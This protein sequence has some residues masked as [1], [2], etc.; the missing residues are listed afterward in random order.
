MEIPKRCKS[1]Q[2]CKECNYKA[3]HLSWKE[4][5][6]LK[7]IE[8]GLSYDMKKAKWIAKYPFKTDPSV[9]SDNRSQAL[10]LMK[11]LEKRLIKTKML[12]DFNTQF[13]DA[14]DRGVFRELEDPSSYQGPVNYIS[15][16]DTYKSRDQVTTPI[17]L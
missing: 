3:L 12:D 4:N 11:G 2:C 10:S 17:H 5:E 1:C 9:L 6:E 14:V 15:L 13:A 8:D 7:A 16:L